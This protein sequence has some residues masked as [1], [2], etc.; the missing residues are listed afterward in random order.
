MVGER[1]GLK[2]QGSKEVIANPDQRSVKNIR[3][4]GNLQNNNYRQH[5]IYDVLIVIGNNI[6]TILISNNKTKQ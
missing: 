4:W 5:K 6:L 2:I 1:N 3:T